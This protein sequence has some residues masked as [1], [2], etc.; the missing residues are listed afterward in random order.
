MGVWLPWYAF[1]GI[2]RNGGIYEELQKLYSGHKV[3]MIMT[4]F[5]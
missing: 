3:I 1:I 4:Y 5:Y 2:T